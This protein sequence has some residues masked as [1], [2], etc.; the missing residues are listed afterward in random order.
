MRIAFVGLSSPSGY[1][2]DHKKKLF[3]N[4]EWKWNPVLES[5]IGI[6]TLYDEIWFFH[7][8]LCP[9]S[10]RKENYVKFLNYESD[11][12]DKIKEIQPYFT[13]NTS[14]ESQLTENLLNINYNSNNSLREVITNIT[15]LDLSKY[16]FD[17]HSHTIK[18]PNGIEAYGDCWRLSNV[19]IDLLVKEKLIQLN[20]SHSIELITNSYT[21][22]CFSNVQLRYN[23]EIE[24]KTSHKILIKR[25]PEIHRIEGPILNR[26]DILRENKYVGDFRDKVSNSKYDYNTEEVD[27]IVSKIEIEFENYRNEILL[28]KH[29]EASVFS[30]ISS[31]V[32]WLAEKLTS[33]VPIKKIADFVGTFETRRMN[34]AAFMAELEQ[35]KNK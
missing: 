15:G 5:P 24:I 25:I 4:S 28:N 10:M 26:I 30:S 23:N 17:N 3:K 11:F 13:F 6:S 29:R 33:K 31:T 27:Q 1:F 19:G 22:Q 18:F 9:Y 12:C 14:F 8:A 7:E 20:P 21:T 32:M 16:P 2:Y 35:S 34:W